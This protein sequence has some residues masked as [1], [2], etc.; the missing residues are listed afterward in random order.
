LGKRKQGNIDFGP[1]AQV[2]LAQLHLDWFGHWLRG[3]EGKGT[4]DNW[5]PVRVFVMGAGRWQNLQEWPPRS[6]S[7]G[8]WFLDSD[9]SAN[10]PAGD[11]RLIGAAPAKANH[12]EY[13]YDPRDPVPTLWTPQLFTVPSDQGP[14]SKRR[15]ILVYQSPPLVQAVETIGYPE[16]VL[17]AASNCPDTD[18][19]ARL[20]DVAPDGRAID[21]ASGMI[22]AR[23]RHSLEKPER[24]EPGKITELR[25]RLRPTAHRFLPGHRLRLDI[26]SSDFP[27]YDR[28]H[29]TAADQNA[30]AEL[31]VARQSI[32][33]GTAHPSRLIL[34]LVP[35]EN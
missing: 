16:V 25:I 21:V 8:E 7:P 29:N 18:F 35:V 10:T 27:N 23:Y 34:P 17:A 13:D 3:Q 33:H 5:G 9:G 24:L 32:H 26:T 2:D 19:F 28:N 4:L 30:D 6:A 20:I 12:D 11:G 22:R 15:D 1:A 31:A 14:L